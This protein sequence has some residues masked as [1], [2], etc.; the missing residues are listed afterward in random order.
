MTKRI[1]A[2]IDPDV[3]RKI[4]YLQKKTGQ[5]TTEVLKASI[6][7]YFESLSRQE[8]S[9]AAVLADLV[10]CADGPPDL[11]GDYKRYLTESL[12]RKG[13]GRG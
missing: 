4:R 1:N 11:A 5:T 13:K 2:R 3:A 12:G 9:P 7:A 10:G 6:E 8:G